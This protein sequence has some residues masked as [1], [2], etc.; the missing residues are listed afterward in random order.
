MTNGR[1]LSKLDTK[2]ALNG[3]QCRTRVFSIDVSRVLLCARRKTEIF[4]EFAAKKAQIGGKSTR[5][6]RYV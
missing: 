2:V 4:S 5:Q 3:E 6:G 1:S